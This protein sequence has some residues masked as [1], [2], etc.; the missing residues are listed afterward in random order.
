MSLGT[1]VMSRQ[2]SNADPKQC[3]GQALRH[4]PLGP[5]GLGWLGGGWL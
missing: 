5:A 3:R 2:R 4:A 1:L